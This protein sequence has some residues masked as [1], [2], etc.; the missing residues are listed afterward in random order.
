[1]SKRGRG[2]IFQQPGCE[3][4]TIQYYRDGRRVREAVG[5]DDYRAAQQRLTQ[6][7]NQCDEGKAIDLPRKSATIA[8]LWE[9]LERHYRIN[10]RKSTEC[11]GRR[12]QH[13]RARFATMPACNVT[14]D[15]LENYVDR[16]LTEHA[17]N[18]TINR[19]LS[20]LKT[21]FRLGRKKQIVSQVPDFPHLAENNAR[22]GFVE[23]RGYAKLAAHCSEL[24]M[25]LFLEIAYSFAWRKSEILNLRV[26]QVS[27]ESRTLRLDAGDTKNGEGRE[28]R[29]T[30]RI[31]A[32]VERA[33]VG[34]LKADYLLTRETGERIRD[35]RKA[36]KN[37][38]VA[39]G[40]EGLIVHDL[41]RSGARQLRQAGV[42]ESVVMEIGGWKTDSMFR[43]YA[44]VS[45]ADIKT[46]IEQL[47]QSRA[48]N[49][50]DFSHDSRETNGVAARVEAGKVN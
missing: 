41:R 39:A 37:L 24:W 29:M 11:L 10:G 5:S 7:L 17:A 16:R 26:G 43:R 4:W 49:S 1:M 18:A 6:R 13:L 9:G 14:Y 21:A 38:T 40:L 28:V 46:G 35:F 15:A 32:L 12:W 31:A 27:L 48:E 25:R 45:N 2:S 23:D 30:Q 20:A 33:V 19:E 3:T 50:H 44:I 22:S 8:E 47:E 34:K 36:W 42:P